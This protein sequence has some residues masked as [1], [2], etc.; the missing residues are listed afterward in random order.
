MTEVAG[1]HLGLIFAE[2]MLGEV[3]VL[4]NERILVVEDE[5]IV[6]LHIK[7][8]LEKLGYVVADIA[9]TGDDAI[10]KAMEGR[11]D[12]VLMD[13]V[14]K[15]AVDG[16]DAAEKIRALFGIP[17][18][19][20][21]A[22]ADEATVQRAKVTE[23][24]GYIVKPF[25][26]RDLYISIE[27]ALYRSKMEAD[28][29]SLAGQLQDARAKIKT[30]QGLIPVCARCKKIRNDKRYWEQLEKFISENTGVNFSQGVCPECEGRVEEEEIAEGKE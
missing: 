2:T 11:P 26:T 23:P 27:F 1:L 22:H 10:M 18:I 15:G 16:V 19:Y 3:L 30:L 29:K 6:V 20:L 8:T 9:S 14:L 24:F 21:T 17:V 5:G 25:R 12:L 28:R 7:K 13:V 4:A